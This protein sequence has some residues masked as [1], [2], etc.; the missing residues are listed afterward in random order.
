LTETVTVGVISATGRSGF[1]I[2][3]YEDFIQ[4]DAAINP[5]NSGGPLVNIKGEVIG[6]N[7][8]IITPYAAQNIGFAIPINIAKSVFK[9]LKEK[10]KVVRGY[11]G[12]VLQPLTNDLAKSFG[13]NNTKGAVVAQV[14]SNSPAE[15]GGLKIGDVIVEFDGQKIEDVKDLQMKVANTPVGK[16]VKVG[17]LR[18]GKPMTLEVQVGEMPEEEKVAKAGEEQQ[19]GLWFGM[20]VSEITDQIANKYGLENKEGVIVVYVE[21]GSVADESGIIPGS[22]IKKIDKY[23]ITN[24]ADFLEAKKNVN[25]KQYISVWIVK[26]GQGRFV[27]LKKSE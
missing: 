4:T 6:I 12:I 8:F 23:T 21:Q 22:V 14:M 10:G 18:D 27:V 16:K 26:N 20:K 25:S 15:K 1:G 5:G 11:L 24:Y 7:T 3:Q 2:T 17:I 9:Q 13:L 19:S